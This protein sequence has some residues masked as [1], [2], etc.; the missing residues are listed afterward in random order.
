MAINKVTISGNLTRDCELKTTP[1]G[2][3]VLQFTV[4]VND[5]RKTQDGSWGNKANYIDCVLFGS[6]AESLAIYFTKGLKLAVAGK[7]SQYSWEKDGQRHS[8]IEILADDVDF[9]APKQQQQPQ[10]PQPAQPQPTQQQQ[11]QAGYYDDEIPF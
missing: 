6:R 7:L 4:A 1:G 5:R 10:Q 11:A 9:I 8:K 2:M 3:S